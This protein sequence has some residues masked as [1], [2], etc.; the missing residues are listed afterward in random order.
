[1]REN[2]TILLDCLIIELLCTSY[3]KCVP[4][5]DLCVAN[6]VEITQRF[7]SDGRR[8]GFFANI[9]ENLKSEYAKSE[10]MKDSL[11]KFREEA[12]KLEESEALKEAR[13]KFESIESETSKSSNVIKEQISGIADKVKDAK[14]KLDDIEALK[15]ATQIGK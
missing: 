8:P 12:Q 9:V 2:Q 15:K 4:F 13:R 3:I 6:N 10:E 1:M 14:E 11:K 7:Y 5:L